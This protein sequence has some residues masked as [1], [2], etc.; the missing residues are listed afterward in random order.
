MSAPGG[1]SAPVILEGMD[2]IPAVLGAIAGGAIRL[3]AV[4]GLRP[5]IGLL[6]SI[7]LGLLAV[8]LGAGA[9]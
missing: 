8:A 2:E 9:R 1:A 7:L 5:M 4:L 3:G 6:P